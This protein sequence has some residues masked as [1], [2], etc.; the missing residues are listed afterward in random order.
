MHSDYRF[1]LEVRT[2]DGAVLHREALSPDWEPAVEAT[3][4]AALRTGGVWPHTGSTTPR[5]EPVWHAAA[6]EPF[7]QAVRVHTECEG[8]EWVTDIPTSRY[9]N[10]TARSVVAAQ[11]A[12][13]RIH[14][15]DRVRYAVAAYAVSE[16]G[17]G[18]P[19]LRFVTTDRPQTLSVRDRR[20]A[21]LRDLSLLCGEVDPA[22][23][24][25]VLPEEVLDE[26]CRLTR[27]AGDRETGGILLGHLC[28]DG[29][30]GDIGLE[31]TAHVPARHTVGDAVKLTFTSDTW[32]DVR[33]AVA[34]RRADE[35]LVGWWHSHPAAAWC[36]QCPSER[37]RVCQLST[38]F[39]SSDDQALHR[40]M[41]PE[42]YTQALV[43]TNSIVGLET[44]LFGWR[45]GVLQPRG[46]H[47][48]RAR[49]PGSL[50]RD[51]VRPLASALGA[52]CAEEPHALPDA[53]ALSSQ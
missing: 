42:A 33:A 22:D 1:V 35:L 20:L 50:A 15:E 46:F 47:L 49:I 32:T 10:G 17:H 40:V 9:F 48:R 24:G 51:S 38:G 53:I 28:R 2:L 39:L 45:E 4:L 43:V 5:L 6:G 19:P 26:I 23:L 11:L 3:R 34:L 21:E 29:R 37:Q 13:G 7:V 14:A 16:Q 27:D 41:F 30:V 12:A 25:V 36:R 18:A 8:R 31:V 52:A 44:K